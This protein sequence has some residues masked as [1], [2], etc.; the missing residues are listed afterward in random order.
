MMAATHDW[1]R[2]TR[3]AWFSLGSLA[4]VD[5]GMR[6]GADMGVIDLQHGLW[7]RRSTHDAIS[8]IGEARALVRSIDGSDREINRALDTGAAGVIVPMIDSPDAAAQVVAASRFAPHGRRSAGGVRPVSQG[9]GQYLRKAA[10]AVAVMIET[11]AGLENAEQIAAVDGVSFVFIGPGDLSM[12]LGIDHSDVAALD[13]ACMQI[14]AAC[15]RAQCPSGIFTPAHASWSGMIAKGFSI[16]TVADDIGI[17]S[18]G[19]RAALEA[20]AQTC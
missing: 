9:F 16:A 15:R 13:D 10:P 1:R 5:I 19:F 3:L 8:I 7:D 18:G 4:V 2:P 17:V 6:S 12:S 14:H 20:A 11:R